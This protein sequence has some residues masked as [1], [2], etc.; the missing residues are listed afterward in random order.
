MSDAAHCLPV[1]ILQVTMLSDSCSVA[2]E[3]SEAINYASE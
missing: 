1:N 2:A 3:S